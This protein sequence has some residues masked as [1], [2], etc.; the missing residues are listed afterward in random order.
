MTLEKKYLIELSDILGIEFECASC[1]SKI[2]FV[3]ESPHSLDRCPNCQSNWVSSGTV[4]YDAIRQLLNKFRDA[5]R[6]I[7]GRSFSVRL[8]ISGPQE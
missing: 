7:K 4:E 1:K 8:Q 3:M 5:E 2:T 6:A